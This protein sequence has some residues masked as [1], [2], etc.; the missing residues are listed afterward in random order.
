[1]REPDRQN[2]HKAMTKIQETGAHKDDLKFLKSPSSEDKLTKL[3]EHEMKDLGKKFHSRYKDI[4]EKTTFD[5]VVHRTRRLVD[6]V[7]KFKE[8]FPEGKAKGQISVSDVSK[9]PR[10]KG[11]PSRKEDWLRK[12]GPKVAKRLNTKFKGVNLNQ[13]DVLAIMNACASDSV[14]NRQG[15]GSAACQ[16]FTKDE[17]KDY[18]HCGS[19]ARLYIDGGRS[20]NAVKSGA[21]HIENMMDEMKKSKKPTASA[22]FSSGK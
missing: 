10:E 9:P 7:H 14:R 2:A 20:P 18:D 6:S 4:L 21:Q 5:I 8:G 12:F 1:M 22:T 15:K 17:W 16:I 3:G 19:L 13:N 11:S